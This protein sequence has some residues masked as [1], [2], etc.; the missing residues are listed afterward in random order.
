MNYKTK[1]GSTAHTI[2]HN[3]QFNSKTGCAYSNTFQATST[4]WPYNVNITKT[5]NICTF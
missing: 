1:W 2:I 3:L 5:M 4:I